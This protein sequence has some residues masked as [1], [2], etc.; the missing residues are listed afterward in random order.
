MAGPSRTEP[1]VRSR[2]TL[3][4]HLESLLSARPHLALREVARRF[5]YRD[6]FRD[7]TLSVGSGEV[8]SLIGP[9]GAGKTTLLRVMAGLLGATRGVVERHGSIG[10]VAHHSMLYDAL[11]AREN[12]IF[13][14]RLTG[15]A[16]ETRVRAAL[17]RMDLLHVRDQRVGTF[18]RGMTQRLAFARTLV[19]DSATL[20][21]DEPTSGLDDPACE[22]VVEVLGQMRSEGKAIVIVTH[23]YDRVAS[24]TSSVGFLVNGLLHGPVGDDVG[25]DTVS[26]EYRRLLRG[27]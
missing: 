12:L 23:Q 14:A 6:V 24:V 22:I 1:F 18:S 19:A 4:R 5:A 9:N 21:L 17:E 16:D 25:V 27:G 7:V 13:F 2:D 8:V 26:R 3:A 11:T 10:M 20:L 15:T